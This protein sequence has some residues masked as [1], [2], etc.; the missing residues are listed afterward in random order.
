[1]KKSAVAIPTSL[2]LCRE[3]SAKPSAISTTPDAR[4]TKSGENGT[5][6]GT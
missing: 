4:T 6:G 2:R 5:H 1:M 3:M